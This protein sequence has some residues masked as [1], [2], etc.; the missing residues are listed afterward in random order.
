M[1]E[2]STKSSAR[3]YFAT[4]NNP[5][6]HG[7]T[8]EPQQVADRIRDEWL[9]VCPKGS[10]AVVFC[11]SAGGLQHCHAVFENPSKM[12][13]SAVKKAFPFAHLEETQGSKRDVEDYLA[14][15][16]KFAEKGEK[17]LAKSAAGEVVGKQGKR[18][19][20]QTLRERLDN[21]EHPDVIIADSGLKAARLRAYMM[22]YYVAK[23]QADAAVW[24][25]V[26]SHWL[27]GTTGTGKSYTVFDLYERFGRGEVY[28]VTD[29]VHPFDGYRCER[30]LVLD[31]F[32]GQLPFALLLQILDGYPMQTPAR[33]QNGVACW[34][35][36]YIMSPHPPENC[37]N[38]LR[39]DDRL[40]QLWRRLGDV[41]LC[42]RYVDGSF[43][44]ITSTGKEY[45]ARTNGRSS[46]SQFLQRQA[47]D[48]STKKGAIMGSLVACGEYLGNNDEVPF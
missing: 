41:T 27:F 12:R 2:K 9:K 5:A 39:A 48:E 47:E 38:N 23:K 10:C 29:Y 44:K 3:S 37:Y 22:T 31:E 14:K 28:R 6:E 19:D 46:G 24:R 13:F 20:L 18:S 32:R 16:G 11:V 15:R 36:V 40:G 1:N 8:G 34:T 26:S 35:D 42:V 25:E 17:V 30:V 21:G 45:G 7:Y 43:G 4:L 33:Y